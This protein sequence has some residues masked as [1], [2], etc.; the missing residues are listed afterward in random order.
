MARNKNKEEL[1]SVFL[2][3]SEVLVPF[4]LNDETFDYSDYFKPTSK[5]LIC[6]AL[7]RSAE[8]AKRIVSE[9][10]GYDIRSLMAYKVVT[11]TADDFVE[12]SEKRR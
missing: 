7:A 12:C 1:F 9:K 11:A 5:T 2:S 4:T 8:D 6:E 3:I 10:L